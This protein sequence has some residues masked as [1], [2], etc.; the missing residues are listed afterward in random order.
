M[1]RRYI[2]YFTKDLVG[3]IVEMIGSDSIR[4]FDNRLSNASIIN[5]ITSEKHTFLK[6]KGMIGFRIAKGTILYYKYQTE[7]IKL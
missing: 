3:N 6:R 7:L 2:I 4:G 1:I 5:I